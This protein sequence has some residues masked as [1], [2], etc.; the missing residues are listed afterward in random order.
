MTN[1]AEIEEAVA[2]L[3]PEDLA[4]FRAWF[5]AFEAERLDRRIGEDA[6]SGKLDRFADEAL[7]DLRRG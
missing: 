2:R 7:A 4:M 6:A 5:D 1:V 3:P